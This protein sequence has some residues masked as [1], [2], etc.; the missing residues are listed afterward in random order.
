MKFFVKGGSTTSGFYRAWLGTR[1][2]Y[3]TATANLPNGTLIGIT[4]EAET[5]IDLTVVYPVGSIYMNATDDTNPNTLFGIGTWSLI[6]SKF[7]YGTNSLLS[8]L[9]DTGGSTT[10]TLVQNNL[11]T[12][13]TGLTISAMTGSTSIESTDHTH[14]VTVTI[15]N[16][17]GSGSTWKHTHSNAVAGEGQTS[18]WSVKGTSVAAY[19]Q[20]INTGLIADTQGNVDMAFGHSHTIAE[21]DLQHTHTASTTVSN[22]SEHTT[23]SHTVSV[24][25]QTINLTNVGSG[26]AFSILPTYRKVAMWYRVN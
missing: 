26:T 16:V 21:T 23:H 17:T 15:G 4:D 18:I 7:L 20:A 10:A 19:V 6:D 5:S 8:D 24:D 1:T 2:D 25:S 13:L 12:T 3:D 14:T 9:G 11:P 22:Q